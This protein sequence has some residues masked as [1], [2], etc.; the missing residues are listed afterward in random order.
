MTILFASGEDTGFT[1][2][3][4]S[5]GAVV[6]NSARSTY[7]RSTSASVTAGNSTTVADPPANRFQTPVFTSTNTLWVHA[8]FYI[9]AA[10]TGT[11]GEQ[12]LIV[13][14]PDGVSRIIVR[15]TGTA[16]TL[17]VSTRTA[18]GVITDLATASVAFAATTITQLDLRVDYVSSGVVQ[19]YLGGVQVINW[20]GD[21]RTDAATSLAQADFASVNNNSANNA[22]AWS[23]I[24]CADED[25]R[26]MA[27]WTLTL[28]ASGTTQS[29]S[30]NTVA[31]IN[32][33]VINDSTSIASSAANQLSEWTTV[34]TAPTGSWGVKAVVQ[35]A[36]MEVG[37]TGP[38]HFDWLLRVAG[39]DYLAG[40][41]VAPTSSYANYAGKVWSSNPATATDWDIGDLTTGIQ[42]G[43]KSLA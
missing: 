41:S 19:L 16:G 9:A 5:P 14:S 34:T 29:W 18:A 4:T 25:T 3:G 17:K 20:S 37:V 7:A 36:R 33:A 38:Q 26:G 35:E 22:T 13:R 11:S 43:V 24:I 42:V 8:Q 23:E 12:C 39:A 40:D 6:A 27:L 30:P 2:Y 10:N 31:N 21:P 1:G 32:K 28:V 15:Q